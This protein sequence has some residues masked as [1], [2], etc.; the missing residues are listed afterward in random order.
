[1]YLFDDIFKSPLF[2]LRGK[3]PSC[4]STVHPLMLKLQGGKPRDPFPVMCYLFLYFRATLRWILLTLTKQTVLSIIRFVII[5]LGGYMQHDAFWIF[6]DK[7]GSTTVEAMLSRSGPV[8]YGDLRSHER[9]RV[10][11]NL[12]LLEL[13]EMKVLL[14]GSPSFQGILGCLFGWQVPLPFSDFIKFCQQNSQ[15]SNQNSP[16]GEEGHIDV[17]STLTQPTFTS[18][19]DQVYLAQVTKYLQS[20]LVSLLEFCVHQT[21]NVLFHSSRGSLLFL[22]VRTLKGSEPINYWWLKWFCE[23]ESCSVDKK[24]LFM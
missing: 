10:Y 12:I 1:M 16:T 9:V 21:C 18:T 2:E 20:Y 13:A 15:L 17:T 6:Q 11:I 5:H 24:C 4:S 23:T 22:I 7:V 14:Q 19:N 8:F 3:F